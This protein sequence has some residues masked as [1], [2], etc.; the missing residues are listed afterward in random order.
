LALRAFEEAKKREQERKARSLGMHKQ[1][2]LRQIDQDLKNKYGDFEELLRR[3]REE[4]SQLQD[5]TMSIRKRLNDRRK[6]IRE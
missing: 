3:K 1:E 6:Q 2:V 5:Q 4:E